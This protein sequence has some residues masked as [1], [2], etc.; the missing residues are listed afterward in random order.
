MA[1]MAFSACPPCVPV[2]GLKKESILF[3]IYS[4]LGIKII[5]YNNTINNRPKKTTNINRLMPDIK[6]KVNQ[7]RKTSKV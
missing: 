7:D 5:K 6:T 4:N 2:V 3:L 1:S